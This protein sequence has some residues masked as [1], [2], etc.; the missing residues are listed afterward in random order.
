MKEATITHSPYAFVPKKELSE[1]EWRERYRTRIDESIRPYTVIDVLFRVYHRS[2][3]DDLLE[4][5]GNHP[6]L[7][8]T[9]PEVW[10][11]S[12]ARVNSLRSST[13]SPSFFRKS[14][15]FRW[16]LLWRPGFR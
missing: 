13:L 14:G 9:A 15:T 1:E 12:H 3:E 11:L 7:F 2:F 4:F 10:K 8:Q 5:I 6:E 16:I